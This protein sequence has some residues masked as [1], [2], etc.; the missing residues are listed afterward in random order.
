M[1]LGCNLPQWEGHIP[2]AAPVDDECGTGAVTKAGAPVLHR[3][4][5]L[6]AVG[7]RGLTVA[8][9]GLPEGE[10]HLVVARTTLEREEIGRFAARYP[11]SHEEAQERREELYEELVEEEA[12]GETLEA[13]DFY[14]LAA[15]ASGLE[16]GRSYCYRIESSR[17]PLTQWA[18]LATAPPPDSDRTLRFVI[19]GDS[20]AGSPAQVAL[21]RLTERL[22]LDAIFFAGDLAYPAGTLERLQARFF[23]VYAA[24][25]RRV[26]AYAAIGNHDQDADDAEP[27]KEVFFFPGNERWYSFDVGRVHFVVLDT[28]SIGAE[29]ASWLDGDLASNERMFTVVL[30]HHPPYTTA[31]RGPNWAYRSIFV[32]ILER[33]AVDL[34]ISGH[35]HHYERLGPIGGIPYVVTGGGGGRLTNVKGGPQSVVATPRHHY[36]LVEVE[37][38]QLIV[39]AVDIDSQIFDRFVVTPRT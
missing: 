30:G 8:W 28:N 12:E 32:P 20:G 37:E 31:W 21:A 36:L 27:F 23:D 3:A 39:E 29:Q 6:Q 22:E 35:E 15:R 13:D 17:G 18:T 34:V 14:P 7:T 5:Y 1:T 19:L 11:G 33:H 10:P 9:A 4:P 25:L 38:D 24:I 2:S 16:P 26:P